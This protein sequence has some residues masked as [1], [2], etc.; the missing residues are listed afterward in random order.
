MTAPKR[1]EEDRAPLMRP[2][3]ASP[4]E[5]QTIRQ[6]LNMTQKEL[7]AEMGVTEFTVWRWEAGKRSIT[8]ASTNLLR[9]MYDA[10]LGV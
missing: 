3:F 6:V 4:T 9:S 2:P 7:A 8:K 10:A 5:V 1:F